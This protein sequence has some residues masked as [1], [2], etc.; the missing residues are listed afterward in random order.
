MD[1]AILLDRERA[2][3]RKLARVLDVHLEA[4][5]TG[6]LSRVREAVTEQQALALSLEAARRAREAELERL[7][8]R[9]LADLV[10]AAALAALR[11]EVAEVERRLVVC[12]RLI[13]LSLRRVEAELGVLVALV[14]PGGGAVRAPYSHA[15]EG[16]V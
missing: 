2:I 7:A 11:R 14:E 9:R 6:D 15:L 1:P 8:P 3:W 10:P 12:S 5:A 13:A 4:L 16:E